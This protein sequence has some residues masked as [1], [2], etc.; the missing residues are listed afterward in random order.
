MGSIALSAPKLRKGS[1]FPEWLLTARKR[2]EQALLG[3]V[4]ECYLQGVSM[5]KVDAAVQQLGIEGISKRRSGTG[6][7]TAR[8]TRT[9]GR[10]Q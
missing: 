10:M 1:Y 6:V 5:R 8:A 7:C 3:V 4:A 2:S 9:C